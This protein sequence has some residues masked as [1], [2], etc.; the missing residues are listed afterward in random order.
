MVAFGIIG[1]SEPWM[2]FS[3]FCLYD[4]DLISFS[5][6]TGKPQRTVELHGAEM[7]DKFSGSRFP[8]FQTTFSILWVSYSK[9]SHVSAFFFLLTK[10]YTEKPEIKK[11]SET[12]TF[13]SLPV[14]RMPPTVT[15]VPFDLTLMH[16][17]FEIFLL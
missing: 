15:P 16:V 11:Q 17:P 3:F 6:L 7:R 14:P 8:A 5:V 13:I 12:F 2:H 1:L 10:L 9:K 4:Y